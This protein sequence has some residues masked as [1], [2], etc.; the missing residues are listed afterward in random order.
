MK[1]EKN[2]SEFQEAVEH[3]INRC[4]YPKLRKCRNIGGNESRQ[5]KTVKR[6]GGGRRHI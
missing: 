6:M 1:G 3:S 2:E 4:L 5:G